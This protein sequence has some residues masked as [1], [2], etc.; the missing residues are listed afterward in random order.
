[1]EGRSSYL[2]FLDAS[3]ASSSEW[4]RDLI[5]SF[6]DSSRTKRAT[7]SISAGFRL[8]AWRARDPRLRSYAEARSLCRSSLMALNT[9]YCAIFA[10]DSARRTSGSARGASFINPGTSKANSRNRARNASSSGSWQ[11]PFNLI[12]LAPPGCFCRRR[13]GWEARRGS[14]RQ[15]RMAL[16]VRSASRSCGCRCDLAG[17][18]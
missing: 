8:S 5:P 1:M 16:D 15:R 10:L 6:R 4:A 13:R 14:C 11:T 12:P 18:R 7:K 3:I 2:I 17:S 9:S